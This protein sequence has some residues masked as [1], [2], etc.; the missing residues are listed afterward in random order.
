MTD[1]VHDAHRSRDE[2]TPLRWR[3]RL[4]SVRKAREETPN[5]ELKRLL[6]KLAQAIEALSDQPGIPADD[7]LA[8]HPRSPVDVPSGS[9]SQADR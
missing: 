5:N 9:C 4:V 2:K 1:H 3:E 7:W 8:M 6:D